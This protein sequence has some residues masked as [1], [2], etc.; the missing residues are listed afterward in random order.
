MITTIILNWNRAELLK[1]T[2]ESYLATAGADRELIV[3]DNAST[4]E[5]RAYLRAIEAD[6][7][8][9]VLYLDDNEGGAAYNHAIPHASGD[10][11]HL[12]END[13]IFQP[14]WFEHVVGAF[15][16][17]PALGQLSLFGAVPTDEEAWGTK[18]SHLVFSRGKILY[19][20][21]DNVTT[22]S[23][24]RA[25][26]FRE[27]G[28]TV[29]NI[30]QGTFRFPDDTRL[31]ADVKTA[32]FGVAWSDRYYIRNVGHEVE[33]FEK[34]PEYYEENYAS[35]PWI[36]VEGWRSR[37]ERQ[38]ATPRPQRTSISLPD[39]VLVP[40]ITPKNVGDKPG[41]LWSMFDGFSAE[42]EVVDFIHV[43][44]K[45]VK[46]VHVL[47]TGTWM[48]FSAC[49]I[50]RALIANGLGDLTTLEVHP[51][52][53]AAALAHFEQYGV[54]DAVNAVRISS[55]EYVPDRQFDMALFDT[56]TALRVAEFRRFLP[57]L[58][59]GAVVLFRDTTASHGTGF[60]P[61]KQII[62]SGLITAGINFGTPRGLF[63][64]MLKN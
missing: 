58:A 36:G 22:T 54:S 49:A 37:I 44:T 42:S 18:P 64:G 8:V 43:L 23:V 4:D 41:R 26:L 48:G 17:F 16:C 29:R 3:V 61:L 5:S 32:G 1:K 57:H 7:G 39:R 46:P 51:E 31:S 24:I 25:S 40:E 34:N 52:A 47:E 30:E 12:C 20:A 11:I 56:D 27:K 13:V 60:A 2:V 63:V 21:R 50:A 14:G 53:H 19:Q 59:P 35:K 45:L 10:L 28:L 15:D 9:R 33:E 55:M 38:K 62:D 6:A